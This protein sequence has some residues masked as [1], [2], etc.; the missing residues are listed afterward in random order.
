[1][2]DEIEDDEIPT[3][4]PST[5][6]KAGRPSK[7]RKYDPKIFEGKKPM[8][9]REVLEWVFDHIGMDIDVK[10]APTS[11]AYTLL[12]DC[13]NDDGF[14]KDFCRTILPKYLPT[15]QEIE[16]KQSVKDNEIEMEK[17]LDDLINAKKEAIK[18]AAK[19]N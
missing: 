1:M 16:Q 4:P 9:P 10:D 13:N 18:E 3:P 12:Q 17:T 15:K 6:S 8:A 5:K 14:R 11:L 2:P 19:R 7:V